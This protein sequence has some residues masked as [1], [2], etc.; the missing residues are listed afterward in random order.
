MTYESKKPTTL[1]DIINPKRDSSVYDSLNTEER[2]KYL[3]IY[4][5]QNKNLNHTQHQAVI[6]MT[7]KEFLCEH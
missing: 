4:V 7:D 3:T 1:S 2:L 5:Q 6:E